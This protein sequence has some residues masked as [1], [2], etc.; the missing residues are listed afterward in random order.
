[1]DTVSVSSS[2]THASLSTAAI[3]MMMLHRTGS[4]RALKISV[5]GWNVASMVMGSRPE[6]G[7]RPVMLRKADYFYNYDG[8]WDYGG[9][10]GR[11]DVFAIDAPGNDGNGTAVYLTRTAPSRPGSPW[12]NLGKPGVGPS[13]C[14]SSSPAPTGTGTI[15]EA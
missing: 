12:T 6:G 11:I 7:I 10:N 3:C 5:G 13:A 1:M 2:V 14:R 9:H 15:G 4:L 8:A